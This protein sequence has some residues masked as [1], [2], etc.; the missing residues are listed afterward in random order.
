VPPAIEQ[1]IADLE[2]FQTDNRLDRNPE[3]QIQTLVDILLSYFKT[4]A[5]AGG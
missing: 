2:Q 4:M 1:L 3:R 5:E